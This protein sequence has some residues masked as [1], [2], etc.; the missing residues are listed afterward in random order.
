VINP[1]GPDDGACTV[2]GHLTWYGRLI[3]NHHLRVIPPTVRSV[4]VL[5]GVNMS[6]TREALG[7]F[8]LDER[9]QWKGCFHGDV[10]FSLH[11]WK[12]GKILLYDPAVQV[13]H[14]PAR[15]AWAADRMDLKTNQFESTFNLTYVLLKHLSWPRKVAFLAYCLLV[16]Q[17][18]ALGLITFPYMVTR[19]DRIYGRYPAG[20]RLQLS[21]YAGRLWAICIFLRSLACERSAASLGHR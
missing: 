12:Q 13:L 18:T 16:G 3:G 6:F 5:K 7:D 14:R 10:D 9:L 4:S 11:V 20:L 15:R 2:V 19:R 21:A 8:R 1:D 17:R